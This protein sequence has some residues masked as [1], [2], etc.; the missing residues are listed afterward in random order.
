[1]PAVSELD[2]PV[3]DVMD[4]DLRGARF[5][6]RVR[7]LGTQGWL[8]TMPLGYVVLDREAANFFLRTRSATF[9]GM[10]IAE[11]FEVDEGPLRTEME[12]NILHLNGDDHTRLRKL[13]NP[14][15]TPRAA[16]RH[17]EAMRGLLAELMPSSPTE[18]VESV[19]KP[20]P[21][22]VIAHVVGAPLTDAPRLAHWSAWI[23][24]QF[25]GP[26]LMADRAKIEE[27]CAEFYAYADDLLAQEPRNLI[28]ELKQAG[29]T[30]VELS[31]L[32]LNVLVGGVDTTVSQLAHAI[33]LFAEHPDQW[34]LLREK[35]EL[36][37]NAVEEALRLQPVTPFTARICLEDVEYRDVLFPKDTVVMVAACTAN[38]D[39]LDA[40]HDF[41]IERAP[42]KPVTFGAGVHYCLGANLARAELEEALAFLAPRMPG[43]ALDGPPAYDSVNG[44]YGLEALPIRFG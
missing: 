6:E 39:D 22:Q 1:M 26:S 24:R 33:R 7:E 16:D 30:D 10:K 15:F 44:I 21:A 29:L 35:P 3:F 8:A 28:A 31:N 27:A 36:V 40:A 37:P 9:P 20:Y 34:E 14:A 17:R 23:Q 11:I 13:V 41:D 12:H 5:E 25:D 4:G 43:L 19:A 18:F 32:V 38:R 2:L 42:T